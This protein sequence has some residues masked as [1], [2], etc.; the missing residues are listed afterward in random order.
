MKPYPD[1]NES[2]STSGQK[3]VTHSYTPVPPLN[4]NFVTHQVKV[5]GLT[6]LLY[7][8]GNSGIGVRRNA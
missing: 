7:E 1:E 5:K 6:T 3:V 8:N 4:G 2:C